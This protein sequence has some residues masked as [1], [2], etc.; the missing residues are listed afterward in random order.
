MDILP[1]ETVETDQD[2]ALI[3]RLATEIVRRR[4]TTPAILFLESVKPLN[5]I[6]SQF[7]VFLDPIVRLFLT[8]PEYQRFARLLEERGTIERLIVAIE[9][10][11]DA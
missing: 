3:E 8:I 6:G 5:F 4:L 1:L 2:E 10:A 11:S 9:G 7:L